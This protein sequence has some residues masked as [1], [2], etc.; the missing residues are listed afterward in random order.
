[1]E[2]SHE[3]GRISFPL[4]FLHNSIPNILYPF[5]PNL[6]P[7]LP[8]NTLQVML[9]YSQFI[10][11]FWDD[12]LLKHVQLR[13]SPFNF[14]KSEADTHRAIDAI[15]VAERFSIDTKSLTLYR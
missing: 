4:H 5:S 11:V 7:V 12:D 15:C 6:P 10:V 9:G 2:M 3:L 8:D 14:S 1:M 13:I